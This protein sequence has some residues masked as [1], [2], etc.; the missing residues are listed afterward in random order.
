MKRSGHTILEVIMSIGILAV[1]TVSVGSLINSL[2]TTD[3]A[4]TNKAQAN[5]LAQQALEIA[6]AVVRQDFRCSGNGCACTPAAGYTSCWTT[7][8][9]SFPT[10]TAATNYHVA[11]TGGVWAFVTGTETIGT[12]PVFTRAVTISPVN[13][14]EQIKQLLATVTWEERSVTRTAVLAT[15]VSAW[16]D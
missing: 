2:R 9:T 3:R 16:Q 1:A 10:C 13:G 12:A 5:A 6:T 11:K 8:P 4:T 7:C 15:I 14:N